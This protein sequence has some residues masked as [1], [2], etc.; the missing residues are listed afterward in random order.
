MQ[1]LVFGHQLFFGLFV[2]GVGLASFYRADLS[3]LGSIVSANA[4]GALIGVDFIYCVTLTDCF[5]RTLALACSTTDAVIGNL[6]RHYFLL[7]YL[8]QF[9]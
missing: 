2:G 7:D 4:F 3:T 9:I 8:Q 6:V 5:I 1:F